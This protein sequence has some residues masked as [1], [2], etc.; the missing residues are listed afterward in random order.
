MS[1]FGSFRSF[2]GTHPKS[3]LGRY[4]YGDFEMHV[5]DGSADSNVHVGSFCSIGGNNKLYL[6]GNHRHNYVSSFP[7]SKAPGFLPSEVGVDG[8]F[9]NYS[10]GD[11]IIGSDVWFGDNCVVMS[12]I[13]IG[14]GAVIANSS[15]VTKDVA[16]YAIVGGNPAKLIKLRFSEDVIAKLLDI[17]WWD[18]P[19]EKI[20]RLK[21]QLFSSDLDTFFKLAGT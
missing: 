12:G 7:F 21:P 5:W 4:T 13:T 11:I 6:G 14:H 18:W 16:P 9:T 15:V 8:T 17:A 3:S 20:N 19:D 10:N 1:Y 2:L